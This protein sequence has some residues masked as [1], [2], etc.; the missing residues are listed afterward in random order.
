MFSSSMTL[1]AS[2]NAKDVNSDTTWMSSHFWH[3][4][5]LDLLNVQNAIEKLLSVHINFCCY[6]WIS[7]QPDSLKMQMSVENAHVDL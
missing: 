6:Q 3:I 2:F 4:K 1:I 5:F 7:S